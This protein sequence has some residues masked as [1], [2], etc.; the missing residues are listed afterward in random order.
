MTQDGI[1][2]A[3]GCKRERTKRT[4]TPPVGVLIA[5][6][7]NGNILWRH[8]GSAAGE[9]VDAVW[10]DQG[11]VVLV[12]E[13]EGFGDASTG[14]EDLYWGHSFIAAY[15]EKGQVWRTDYPFTRGEERIRTSGSMKSILQMADGYLVSATVNGVRTEMK[16]L[17]FDHTGKLQ[18]EWNESIGRIYTPQKSKLLRMG[19]QAFLIAHGYT[20]TEG[21]DE[22]GSLDGIPMKTILQEIRIPPM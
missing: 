22:W 19:D 5:F 13:T 14:D 8:D 3:Y 12:G 4:E 10:A 20:E 17:L 11:Y 21:S 9:F 16:M 15:N 7:D 2:Y 18:K 1:H 6:D